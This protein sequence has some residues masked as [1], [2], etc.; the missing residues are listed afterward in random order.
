MF[1]KISVLKILQNY[2]ENTSVRVSFLLMLLTEK[3]LE[4][5]K[6][7]VATKAYVGAEVCELVG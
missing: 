2:H 4:I 3:F 1:L 6:I 5:L 7:D